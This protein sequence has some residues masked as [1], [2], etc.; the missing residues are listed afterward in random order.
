MTQ[1][2]RIE[3][4]VA[5]MSYDDFADDMRANDA[6]E[7]CLERICEAARKIGDRYDAKYPEVEF[8]KLS[9]A[10]SAPSFATTTTLSC[11][12]ASGRRSPNICPC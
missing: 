6:V 9:C 11:Q 1:I 3:S 4:H 7:R 12:I 8:A 10:I 2:A 5:G